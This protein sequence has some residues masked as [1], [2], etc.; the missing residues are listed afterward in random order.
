VFFGLQ[1]LPQVPDAITSAVNS[2]DKKV[3]Q[4]LGNLLGSPEL[5]RMGISPILSE[6]SRLSSSINRYTGA[7]TPYQAERMGLLPG[8]MRNIIR[9]LNTLIE[10]SIPELNK[11]MNENNIPWLIPVKPVKMP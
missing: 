6:I 2:L 1:K 10:K 11:M 5:R 3:D 7:P 4:I 9:E 8:H